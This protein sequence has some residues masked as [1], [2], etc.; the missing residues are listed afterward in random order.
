MLFVLMKAKNKYNYKSVF[1]VVYAFVI[2]KVGLVYLFNFS[3]IHWFKF[4]IYYLQNNF[5]NYRLNFGQMN[6][7]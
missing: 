3:W 4:L 2:F 5:N 6:F 7:E 1:I